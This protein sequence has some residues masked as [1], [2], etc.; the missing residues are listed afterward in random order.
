MMVQDNPL[1]LHKLLT[2]G[3]ED[4]GKL[5]DIKQF[6]SFTESILVQYNLEK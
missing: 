4:G 1:G 6:I 2:L 5:V 3:V